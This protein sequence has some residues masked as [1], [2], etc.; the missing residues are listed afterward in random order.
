MILGRVNA[1][2]ET[3]EQCQQHSRYTNT[4]VVYFQDKTDVSE[5]RCKQIVEDAMWYYFQMLRARLYMARRLR[6]QSTTKFKIHS[7][8]LP[9]L[10]L[11][12][13]QNSSGNSL[14]FSGATI[15][16]LPN[17]VA[18]PSTVSLFDLDFRWCCQE[19]GRIAGVL[20]M[21]TY[22]NCRRTPQCLAVYTS[23]YCE[24]VFVQ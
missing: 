1:W 11:K 8:P 7:K 21:S 17:V 10:G 13:T 19:C 2:Y 4:R 12:S 5:I 3:E 6:F 9:R 15:C 23:V 24:R 20:F 16:L 14:D 22:S 18:T